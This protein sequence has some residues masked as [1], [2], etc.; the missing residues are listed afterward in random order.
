MLLKINYEAHLFSPEGIRDE[1]LKQGHTI[2][3]DEVTKRV[4]EN[5]V[6]RISFNTENKN[7]Y[8]LRHY[9]FSELG[10]EAE[11]QLRIVIGQNWYF[12][13]YDNQIDYMFKII[14]NL[15]NKDELDIVVL[16]WVGAG[17]ILRHNGYRYY[18]HSNEDTSHHKP[19]IHVDKR[20]ESEAASIS[21]LTSEFVKGYI[22]NK[23]ERRFALDYIENNRVWLVKQ[24]NLHTN[25][26]SIDFE[27]VF[28]N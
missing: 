16:L 10:F 12:I 6:G 15:T 18:F 17:E 26:L 4:K 14:N 19:H 20:G 24:W 25:G 9:F 22:S 8:D 27:H 21:I 5:R 2:L 11:L 7:F 3:G 1:G 28:D 13:N 23:K